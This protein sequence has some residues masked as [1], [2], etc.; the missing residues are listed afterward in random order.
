[1]S[2]IS[3]AGIDGTVAD[4]KIIFAIAIKTLSSSIILAHNHP[5][6]DLNPS[7]PDISLTK[8]P[9]QAGEILGVKVLDHIIVTPEGY[10]SFS[11]EGII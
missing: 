11:D 9:K 4:I 8:K 1:M 6:G 10:Y 5:S 2:L 7:N 3:I